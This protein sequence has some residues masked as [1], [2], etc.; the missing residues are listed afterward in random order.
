MTGSTV[1]DGN[2]LKLGSITI[3][4]CSCCVPAPQSSSSSKYSLN[5]S[6]QYSKYLK[7]IVFQTVFKIIFKNSLEN[8]PQVHNE[9]S[10]MIRISIV[11]LVSCTWHKSQ[12]D[13]CFKI[14]V[15]KSP[16]NIPQVNIAV[17]IIISN[18]KF[19]RPVTGIGDLISGSMENVK[20]IGKSQSCH[21]T[22]MM[23]VTT[24]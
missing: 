7:K 9:A 1:S 23:I 10:V 15:K 20:S 2:Y 17:I 21:L 5:F 22:I 24:I 3:K 4:P 13:L 14:V 16:K 6:K 19:R 11:N 12:F 18:I 8:S